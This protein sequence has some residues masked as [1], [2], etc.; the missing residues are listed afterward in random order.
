MGK[1]QDFGHLTRSL[2][3]GFK[4]APYSCFSMGLVTK[5]RDLVV[6]KFYLFS[7]LKI[8]FDRARF[9]MQYFFPLVNFSEILYFKSTSHLLQ[10]TQFLK[11]YIKQFLS[12]KF[13]VISQKQNL[14]PP[15]NFWYNLPLDI[16]FTPTKFQKLWPKEILIDSLLLSNDNAWSIKIT[17][18]FL[19]P[20]YFA[21]LW[22]PYFSA[23][24]SLQL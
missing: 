21:S 14:N 1:Y 7:K 4:V 15:P 10:Y 18:A 8:S 5:W 12:N 9:V 20:N 6:L 13:R 2:H 11:N 17:Q 23:P 22:R 3:I 19:L 16:L 24:V